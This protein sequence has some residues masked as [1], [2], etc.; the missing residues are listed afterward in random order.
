MYILPYHWG[1]MSHYTAELVNAVSKTEETFVLTTEKVPSNYFSNR[2]SVLRKIKDLD[3]S[4][5]QFKG[6][7][8]FRT[9]SAFASF[10][11]VKIIEQIDPDIIHVTTPLIPPLAIYVSLF[12]LGKKYPIVYTKHGM[13]ASSLKN[14]ILVEW[15][16]KPFEK[17]VDI[18]L[19]IIHT[20]EDKHNLL[21]EYNVSEEQTQVIPHGVYTFFT[22]YEKVIPVEQNTVLF[23]GTIGEYKG[24]RHLIEAV[25]LIS[26]RIPDIKIIIA[27]KGDLS[28]YQSLIHACGKS[29]FEIHNGFI[30]DE[31]VAALFQR[32]T[33]VVLPYT[34][35]SGMS[36]VLNIAYAFGKP[37]VVSDVGGLGEAVEHGKTGLLVPPRDPQALADAIIQLLVDSDLRVT[38]EENVKAKAEELSWDSIAK[39]TMEIYKDISKNSSSNNLKVS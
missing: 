34:Q 21:K 31:T 39:K 13:Y 23:F 26:K 22:Q 32:T 7:F 29:S 3:P 24:I 37:V 4:I 8:A 33:I 2:V 10:R 25:P 14:R 18:K 30:P 16:L 1:G 9:I 5:Q 12:R 19:Y 27:G 36:G 38:M 17:I 15:I 20:M 28:P 35:M 6:L 11:N